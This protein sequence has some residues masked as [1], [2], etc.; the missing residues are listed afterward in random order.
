[1]PPK[2]RQIRIEQSGGLAAMQ[3]LET[4]S[5]E[6]LE[7]ETKHRAAAQA[8]LGARAAE[9]Y[10]AA[11]ARAL[12]EAPSPPPGPRSA[13]SCGAWPTPRW[14]SPSAGPDDLKAAVEK[15]GQRRRRAAS[16]WRCASW[17]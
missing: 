5:D 15:L 12:P 6:E 7:R 3:A 16:C 4:R 8:I 10:D 1:M 17:A 9:R 11:A 2:Q 13:C 14:R